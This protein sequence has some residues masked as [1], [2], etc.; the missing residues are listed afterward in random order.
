MSVLGIVSEY[1]P[2]HN[3]HKYHLE[4][5]KELCGADSVVCVMSG[6]FIQRGEP[7]IV[8]K[9]ARTEMALAS[10]AD[11]VI[12]LPVVYAVSSAEFFAYGA[13]RI[14]DSIGI[15]DFICFGSEAGSID[16]LLLIADILNAEP[17]EYKA[18]LKDFLAG[19]LSFPAARE[20]ALIS[21][22]EAAGHKSENM[23]EMIKSSNNILAIEYIKAIK[24]IGSKIKPQII[25]R[26]ANT[27]NSDMLGG[28]ISSATAIRKH[29]L[30]GAHT[31]SLAA[32]LPAQ[33]LDIL[34]RE[35][36]SGRGPVFSAHFSNIILSALRRMSIEET[37]RLP[38]IAEG[39]EN[40]VKTATDNS[41]SLDELIEGISTRRYTRTRIQRCLFTILT[42]LKKQELMQF[43]A[44]GGPQYIRVLGFNSKGRRLLSRINSQAYLPVIVKTADFKN[45]CNPLLARML[46]IEA[47]STDQYVLAF[48]NPD[49]KKSGQEFTH[50][51]VLCQ[52]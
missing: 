18:S 10:G 1:N 48:S 51:P 9:W 2:F 17:D 41:G 30:S 3:G 38:F 46:E 22:L 45:S 32:V 11:L 35:F 24:K 26:I 8:D 34:Q 23:S 37:A 21:Y 12:E 25:R 40:R 27:Y 7:A 43:N 16:E 19:G 13:V 42:G 49:Y 31:D 39:L 29:L 4:L 36:K 28:T 44:F 52:L 14:L 6:N 33:S 5:S 47:A 15:T 50:N 20:S